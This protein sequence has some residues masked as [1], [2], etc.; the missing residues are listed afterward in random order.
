MKIKMKKVISL[1]LVILMLFSTSAISLAMD[2][3]S[4]YEDIKENELTVST[5]KQKIIEEYLDKKISNGDEK[6]FLDV[7]NSQGFTKENALSLFDTSK[8]FFQPY[9]REINEIEKNMSKEKKSEVVQKEGLKD[10]DTEIGKLEK[11]TSVFSNEEKE[12]IT[13]FKKLLENSHN[14]KY[15]SNEEL[16]ELKDKLDIKNSDDKSTQLIDIDKME[17]KDGNLLIHFYKKSD[18]TIKKIEIEAAKGLSLEKE[19]Y[20]GK[21]IELAKNILKELEEVEKSIEIHKKFDK[22]QN[23]FNNLE[24]KIKKLDEKKYELIQSLARIKASY[25]LEE[26]GLNSLK[27]NSISKD[28]VENISLVPK[29]PNTFKD[30]TLGFKSESK[31]F[32]GTNFLK[33]IVEGEFGKQVIVFESNKTETRSPMYDLVPRSYSNN[34][35]KEKV[36]SLQKQKKIDYLGDGKINPDTDIQK[37]KS[38]EEIA[39]SYRIYLDISSK[40]QV[41]KKGVDLVVVVDRS[42]SMGKSDMIFGD[43]YNIPRYAAIH[44]FLNGLYEKKGFIYKF[45]N[46]NPQNNISI[47][48]FG[49]IPYTDGINDAS[50]L[51][52]WTKKSTTTVNISEPGDEGTNYDAGLRLAEEQF[53]KKEN[54]GN[55]KVML[56][57]SDGVPT[58]YFDEYGDRQGN[59]GDWDNNVH[60]VREQ[61]L[62]YN[63]PEFYLRN[64]DIKTIAVGVSRD[65]DS[66]N[67][68]DLSSPDVLKE[69]A[70][71]S[72]GIFLGIEENIYEL[73]SQ[74]ENEVLYAVSKVKVTDILSEYV[75]LDSKTDFK[76]TVTDT[77]GQIK[78]LWEK[79]KATPENQNGKYIKSVQSKK[80]N[81]K[82]S[83]VLTFNPTYK[84]DKNLKFTLSYNITVPKESFEKYQKIGYTSKGDLNT[85][86]PGNYTSS[87]KKGFYSNE[88]AYVDFAFGPEAKLYKEFYEHPVVQ[89]KLQNL[90]IKKVDYSGKVLGKAK[91]SVYKDNPSMNAQAQPLELYDNEALSGNK[92][93]VFVSDSNGDIKIYGLVHGTYYLKEI[94]AP[95]GF[96]K[97]EKPL[98]IQVAR[99]GKVS[100]VADDNF[101]L[102]D[103]TIVV[104]NELIAGYELPMTGGTGRTLIR[105][106]GF[107]LISI[108]LVFYYRKRRFRC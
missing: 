66:T 37:I 67:T 102:K 32:S 73:T 22:T 72:D 28:K 25:S 24:T 63:I 39:D 1:L 41:E 12:L 51:Q 69:M 88:E 53:L 48:D 92:K 13:K 26:Y 95:V 55:R 33:V 94:E 56:F 83:V 80:V 43:F 68:G 49:G 8:E 57:L 42:G 16:L 45:L 75:K 96:S 79:G 65:I 19:I 74:L 3:D 2:K 23:E 108:Y 11:F 9:F 20:L 77:N 87:G 30:F 91:F 31:Y 36:P 59:G 86:Y 34:S 97:V 17:I 54:S 50:L 105:F 64:P 58:Y 93:T 90:S 6:N 76:V 52:D 14:N 61:M 104:K 47:V 18:A 60:I 100:I 7:N 89:V 82:E 70:E 71:L 29:E 5:N 85:D 4:F 62:N 21:E 38:P 46:K 15:L 84:L 103:N 101:L 27:E 10:E 106:I 40:T 35:Y 99:L 98:K 44:Y 78:T 107:L 81:G